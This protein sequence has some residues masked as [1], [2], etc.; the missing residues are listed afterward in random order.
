MGL[1]KFLKNVIKLRKKKST[2]KKHKKRIIGKLRKKSHKKP[3]KITQRKP[4]KKIRKKT[5]KRIQKKH[6]KVH[7]TKKPKE[8]ANQPQKL[9]EKEIGIITH[10]FG[11]ISVGIIKLKSPLAVGEHIHI[12]DAHDD[13]TQV[14]SS[15]QYN[16]KD[17][18]YAEGGLEIGIKV[19]K[20]VHE[21]DI[22]YKI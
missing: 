18:T 13:F 22:V 16:H 1:F 2:H 6:R 4:H 21:N 9:K 15:M 10:Y 19:I 11:K 14:V 17:I 20:D 7:K 8:S 5:H 12:K 3:H